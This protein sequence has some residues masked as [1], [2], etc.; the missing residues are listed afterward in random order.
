MTEPRPGAARSALALLAG[1]WDR[2]PILLCLALLGVL[3]VLGAELRDRAPPAAYADALTI[4]A[5]EAPIVLGWKALGQHR[6]PRSAGT[7]H[8]RV[9][10]ADGRWSIGNAAG[11]RRVFVRTNRIASRYLQRWRLRVGDQIT[12]ADAELA[13]EAADHRRLVLVDRSDGRRV[14]W[15]DGRLAP[16]GETVH[17]VCR[18]AASRMLQTARWISR[19]F[20]G[21]ARPEFALFSIGGGLNCSD[22]WKHATLPPRSL[23]VTWHAGGFWLAPGARRYDVLLQRKGGKPF[24]FADLSLPADGPEGRIE[25]IILGRTNYRL[26]AGPEALRLVPVAN[27]DFWIDERPERPVREI[28]WAGAG[29][30]IVPWLRAQSWLTL[31]G[32]GAAL[33]SAMLIFLY[34]RRRRHLGLGW[35]LRGVMALPAGLLG[36]WLTVLLMR[37]GSAPDAMLVAGMSWLSWAWATLMLLTSG[38]LKAM[39][40]WIWFA[41][42]FLAGIGALTLLQLGAGAENS[43]WMSFVLK[44]AA[45][46]AL[47][48]WTVS[49]MCALPR[50][51]WQ[52]IW[53]WVFSIE[54]LTAGLAA[55]L[56]VLMMA[57]LALGSEEGIGGIQPVEL[58][59]SVFVVLLAFAG[60]NVLEIRRRES[61]AYQRSPILFLLPFLRFIAIFLVVVFSVVVGVRDFSPAIILSLVTLAWLWK[62]GGGQRGERTAA[63]IWSLLR[64]GVLLALVGMIGAGLWA[65]NNAEALPPGMPQK[66]RVLVW[67][68]PALHPHSGSQVLGAMDRVS[69]GGRI[70]ATGWF[71]ANDR[72]MTLPAVQDDFIVAFLLHRFGAYA[73]LT[74][75]GFQILYLWLLFS[76]ARKVERQTSQADFKLQNAG[77]VLSFT[78]FGLSWMQIAHWTIAWCNTLGLLP[79]MG[80]PMTWLSAGNSHLLGF[81]LVTLTI[82]LVTSWLL[83]PA[84]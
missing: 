48:G 38:R 56:V 83:R 41:A 23:T 15:D 31:P 73:G 9:M 19:N 36:G 45:L 55:V 67:A 32:A 75:L 76:L 61:R 8:L 58:T 2:V 84:H 1:A 71:A 35:L 39:G 53:F 59:K 43:R 72:V 46:V 60:M 70:G 37:G 6:G 30:G 5:V 68:E 18:T 10:H 22:R 66:D 62:V 54:S 52:R 29:A 33:L 40:G 64:P 14:T 74:L 57:Q 11:N 82:A 12:L 63:G 16:D 20:N 81:A 25:R 28:A 51:A 80:Q 44:H 4:K 78:L 79:V 47:F 50:S 26:E 77:L 13:V 69:E 3:F 21:D 49:L 27:V 65:H 34:W 17:Q 42:L 7:Q 24:G